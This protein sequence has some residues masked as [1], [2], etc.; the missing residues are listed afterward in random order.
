MAGDLAVDHIDP[1]SQPVGEAEAI[2]RLQRLEQLDV[3]GGRIVVVGQAH[4]ERDLGDPP[5]SLGWDPRDRCDS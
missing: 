5:D 3:I 4:F 2:R 1:R